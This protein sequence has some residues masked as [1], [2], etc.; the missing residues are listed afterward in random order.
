MSQDFE[1][2]L[3]EKD[4]IIKELEAQISQIQNGQSQEPK[5]QNQITDQQTKIKELEE[6]RQSQDDKIA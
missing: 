1:G 2:K 6:T 5:L 3:Q 4:N